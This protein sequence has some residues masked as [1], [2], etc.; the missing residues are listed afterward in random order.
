M[1]MVQVGI[2]GV[3][4]A[5]FAIQ[6]QSEK[7]E[8][9]IYI[10]VA[11]SIFIFLCIVGKLEIIVETVREIG[12]YIRVG[13]VYVTTLI[14][15]LGITYISEFTSSICK[16]TGHT[17]LATQIEMFGKLTIIVLSLPALLALLKTIDTFL[18]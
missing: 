7:K 12:G 3:M 13:G 11:V 17:T 6:F 14:K 18:S 15:I 5:L 8:Y 10:S 2:I 4:G 9:G 1:S 16:D